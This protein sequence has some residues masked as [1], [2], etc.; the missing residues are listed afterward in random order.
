MRRL[1]LVLVPG[2]LLLLSPS[3]CS[4][5]SS[6]PRPQQPAQGYPQ[7]GY[8]PQQ[9]YPQ[10]GY[11]QQPPPQGYPQQQP[12]YPQNPGY[13]PQPAPQAPAPSYSGPDPI[14]QTNITW[15]RRQTG[16]LMQ[17][18]I[19]ALPDV[20]KQRVQ[21]IPLA[22]DDTVGE[23]NAFA[24]CAKGGPVMVVTD[25]LLDIAAHL[26]AA[27]ANDDI[28]GTRKAPEYINLIATRQQ[29]KRPI[30]QPPSNF[31]DPNQANDSRRVA[32]QHDVF[33]ETVGF[34]VGHEL[35]HHHL[36]HLPCT[37]QPGPFGTGELAR[38][39][40]SAVPLFNQPNELAADAAGTNN[41]L[42]MG[43]RRSGYHLTEG[44]ALLMMQFFSGL[45]QS[46][47]IDVLF[48]FES[49]H[50]SPLIRI[51]VI[52]QTANLYRLSGGGW[53]PL[54]RF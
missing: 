8:Y 16:S 31:F 18:L 40:S 7:Q 34:V 54:P 35:A 11:P 41:I 5:S 27:R 10:G 3:G 26:A 45:D 17:E 47:P 14:S 37:G 49:T 32:R 19:A 53:L 6:Q 21:N 23:V 24:G 33:D 43:G 39:L 30:V 1:P 28:F 9:P 44:G 2:A 36:G 48:G 42:A 38:G 51:P 29:P 46:S 22:V 50:P 52:Q 25:G 15:L 4:S 20:A 13:A 12:G